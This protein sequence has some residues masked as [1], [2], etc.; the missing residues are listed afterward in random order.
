MALI[1]YPIADMVTGDLVLYLTDPTSVNP[2]IQATPLD[3]LAAL[4]E[5][6]QNFA[7]ALSDETTPLTGASSTIPK[8]TFHM[9]YS[10]NVTEVKA[11]LTAAGG[12]AALVVVDL[13]DDAASFLSTAITIDAGEK[14]SAT[15]ATP[16]V[17]GTT[18]HLIAADSLIEC[19][20]TQIDTDNTAAG[21][22]VYLIGNV[23]T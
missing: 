12:G 3:Q 18:P 5:V 15:A 19:F 22:K 2:R 23:A 21:L 10:F 11:G 1:I 7:I 4:I 8:A 16:P 9:P 13:H 20:L 14:T 17:L 6:K